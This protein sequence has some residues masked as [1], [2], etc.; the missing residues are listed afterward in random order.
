MS[1]PDCCGP[2][3]NPD[4]IM[5]FCLLHNQRGRFKIIST[6]GHVLCVLLFMN[7]F[8]PYVLIVILILLGLMANSAFHESMFHHCV[9]SVGCLIIL[10]FCLC[11]ALCHRNNSDSLFAN[12]RYKRGMIGK[13]QNTFLCLPFL[14]L[15][16]S[17]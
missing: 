16:F 7:E 11:F 3:I 5:Y 17:S 1:F 8:M 14:L 2:D 4:I 12:K 9:A 15:Q 13:Y 10:A 6:I